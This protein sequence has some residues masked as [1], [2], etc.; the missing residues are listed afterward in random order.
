MSTPVRIST[1]IDT[2][3]IAEIVQEIEIIMQPMEDVKVSYQSDLE[4]PG[5]VH[6]Y[7]H[8]ING[9]YFD[10]LVTIGRS[11]ASFQ[12]IDKYSGA[13]YSK[14]YRTLQ[15]A[16]NA[17]KTLREQLAFRDGQLAMKGGQA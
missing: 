3:N 12:S 14:M 6:I 5:L 1:V 8:N 16:M 11:I 7:L 4:F 10:L 2:G 9:Q 13:H 15:M 17:I